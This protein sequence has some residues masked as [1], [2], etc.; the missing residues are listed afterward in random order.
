MAKRKV[1]RLSSAASRSMSG[2][3]SLAMAITSVLHGIKNQ[4]KVLPRIKS[5]KDGQAKNNIQDPDIDR[6]RLKFTEYVSRHTRICISV[7][8]ARILYLV[9]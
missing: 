6:F 5:D 7:D 1:S 3:V 4:G 9:V 8:R 2:C